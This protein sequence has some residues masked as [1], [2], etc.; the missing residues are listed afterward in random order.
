MKVLGGLLKV[1][2]NRHVVRLQHGHVLDLLT[3]QISRE[4]WRDCLV[5]EQYLGNNVYY[6]RDRGWTYRLV[7][8]GRGGQKDCFG[9]NR[10]RQKP[11]TLYQKSH[12]IPAWFPGG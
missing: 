3:L 11:S 4:M 6:Y 2:L 12:G 1:K 5:N 9:L 8:G 7:W 10:S